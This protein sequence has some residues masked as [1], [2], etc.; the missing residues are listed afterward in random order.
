MIERLAP[1][2]L[3]IVIFLGRECSGYPH[4]LACEREVSAGGATV[5]GSAPVADALRR[6]QAFELGT[7][8]PVRN[9]SVG[10]SLELEVRLD[11]IPVGQKAYQVFGNASFTSGNGGTAVCGGRR[12]VFNET[13]G[14]GIARARVQADAVGA[15]RFEAYFA[16]GYGAVSIAAALEL[17]ALELPSMAPS[18]S[19]SAHASLQPSATPTSPCH[20]VRLDVVGDLGVFSGCYAPVGNYAGKAA[21]ASYHDVAALQQV[22]IFWNNVTL[23]WAASLVVGDVMNRLFYITTALEAETFA[24]GQVFEFGDV[25]AQLRSNATCA[26][27]CPLY[28]SAPSAAPSASAVPSSAPSVSLM[29]SASTTMAPSVYVPP[30]SAAP[31]AASSAGPT[32]VPSL[33]PS[34]A[35]TTLADMAATI[36]APPTVS[37]VAPPGDSGD[38]LFLPILAVLAFL[39][40]VVV[41]TGIAYYHFTNFEAF[42]EAAADASRRVSTRVRRASVRFGESVRQSVRLSTT[43]P[44][45]GAA[46][47]RKDFSDGGRCEGSAAA[48]HQNATFSY[49]NFAKDRREVFR[50]T[51]LQPFPGAPPQPPPPPTRDLTPSPVYVARPPRPLLSPLPPGWYEDRASDGEVFYF[52]E[53]SG[54][55]QWEK[56]T[57]DDT[58]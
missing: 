51:P 58:A 50:P 56:P 42:K 44:P 32:G 6:V 2:T 11:D 13:N 16:T 43:R 10:E 41:L 22:F 34:H 35:P 31:S 45:Y 24:G 21:Y 39:W 26:A 15:V 18:A 5:M 55:R 47:K 54:M 8:Y 27:G 30:P 52:N 36:V 3:L 38:G 4:L 29:P 19:P 17:S 53:Y 12:I 1:S 28:S 20:E 23:D 48:D 57:W 49:E 14:D 33:S 46:M 7:G 9:Y 25:D 37:P 40:I